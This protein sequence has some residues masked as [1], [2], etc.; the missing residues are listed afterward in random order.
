MD[1]FKSIIT[2]RTII[3][4]AVTLVADLIAVWGINMTQENQSLAV[5]LITTIGAALVGGFRAAATKQLTGS[6]AVAQ[7][8]N[9]V[10]AVDKIPP[11]QALV[12]AKA[13]VAAKEAGRA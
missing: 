12:V 8:A 7:A 1:Q 9:H 5:T 11:K 2:S 13:K 6:A 4:A 3:A 10:V